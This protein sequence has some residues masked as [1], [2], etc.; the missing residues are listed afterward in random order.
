M[1]VVCISSPNYQTINFFKNL[2]NETPIVPIIGYEYIVDF[3][4]QELPHP[5]KKGVFYHINELDSSKLY[6][7]ELFIEIKSREHEADA[8]LKTISEPVETVTE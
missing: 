2:G 6:H 1:R 5:A 7:S 3:V 4:V 8:I